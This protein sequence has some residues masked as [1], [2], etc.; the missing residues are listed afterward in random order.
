MGTFPTRVS[1]RGRGQG[2]S[3]LTPPPA[4]CRLQKHHS[5]VSAHP[6]TFPWWYPLVS[7]RR[8]A[9]PGPRQGCLPVQGC[10]VPVRRTSKCWGERGDTLEGAAPSEQVAC[11]RGRVL[12]GSGL[13]RAASVG[14]Q[15]PL[16]LLGLPGWPWRSTGTVRPAPQSPQRCPQAQPRCGVIQS[17]PHSLPF[18]ALPTRAGILC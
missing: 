13:R 17:Q 7:W 11:P 12:S 1:G 6:A 8:R 14:L 2:L 9:Q 4:P 5:P 18:Y 10:R 3:Y 15:L 16:G